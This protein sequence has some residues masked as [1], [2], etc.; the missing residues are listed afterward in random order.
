MGRS[1]GPF[2]AIG[3]S[4]ARQALAELR[5]V[6]LKGARNTQRL[7]TASERLCKPQPQQSSYS[8]SS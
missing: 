1:C 6:A 2:E 5:K 7:L 4:T 3:R 8:P